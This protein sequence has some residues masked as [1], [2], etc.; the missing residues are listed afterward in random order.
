M[1]KKPSL[2]LLVGAVVLVVV[3]AVLGFYP[4]QKKKAKKPEQ[5]N[6]AQ[7]ECLTKAAQDYLKDKL[8]LSPA[9][10]DI[11]KLLSVENTLAKRRLEE[12]FCLKVADCLAEPNYPATVKGASFSSCLRDEALEEYDAV[13]REDVNKNDD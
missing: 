6:T 12:R 9:P 4:A 2:A 13:S 7:T 3:L 5:Q 10:S 11:E 8:A 1:A